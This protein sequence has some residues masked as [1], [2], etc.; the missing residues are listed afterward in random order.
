MVVYVVV[1]S[2]EVV[3]TVMNQPQLGTAFESNGAHTTQSIHTLYGAAVSRPQELILRPDTL[4][5]TCCSVT[6]VTISEKP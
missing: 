1:M 2:D 6:N 5:S 4:Q 3:N